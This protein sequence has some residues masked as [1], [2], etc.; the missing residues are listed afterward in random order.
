MTLQRI[1]NSF[2]SSNTYVLTDGDKTILVDCGDVEKIDENLSIDAVFLTHPHFDHIYGLNK[3]MVRCPLCKI[4]ILQ[5]GT[6]YLSSDRR[7]LSRY[8]ETPYS[9]VS[10]NICEI[11]DGEI[12]PISETLNV[13]VYATPGHN[14]ICASY[15]I[16]NYFFTGDSYIPGIKTVFTLPRSNKTDALSSEE[17]IIQLWGEGIILCPG[18]GKIVEK[19][20]TI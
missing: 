20:Q 19:R 2:L 9:F 7:N 17:Y 14:P 16:G 6:E 18:H 13:R 11:Y 1:E 15:F 4:Y 8:H 5:G 12:I 10:N 3:L